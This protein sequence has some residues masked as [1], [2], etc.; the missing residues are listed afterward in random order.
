MLVMLD[1]SHVARFAQAG[2]PSRHEFSQQADE[3]LAA[4]LACRHPPLY[5]EE[6]KTFGSK[7]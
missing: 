2:T 1:G 7:S 4:P 3:S 6:R 5:A